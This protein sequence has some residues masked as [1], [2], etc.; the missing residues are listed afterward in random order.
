MT[1]TLSVTIFR[2]ADVLVQLDVLR[3]GLL[4]ELDPPDGDGLWPS[5]RA[6]LVQGCF[7]LLLDQVAAG[8]G[9]AAVLVLER[10]TLDP[11]S[12]GCTG[13][14]RSCAAYRRART[15]GVCR[16]LMKLAG[17]WRYSRGSFRLTRRS[18]GKDVMKKA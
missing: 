10:L 13:A 7:V 6:L 15:N 12:P 8:H 17:I 14:V 3:G 11:A 16:A 4:R 5:D 2:L 18:L 1:S 9:R